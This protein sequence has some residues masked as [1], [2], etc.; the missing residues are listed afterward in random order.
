[1]TAATVPLEHVVLRITRTRIRPV[2]GGV[3]R[4]LS[5]GSAVYRALD[6]QE[7][8]LAEALALG[9]ACV[10][11]SPERLARLTLGEAVQGVT[12]ERWLAEG[13]PEA[14]L[15]V[16]WASGTDSPLARAAA[17]ARLLQTGGRRLLLAGED[18]A[19]CAAPGLSGWAPVETEEVFEAS[20]APLELALAS[21]GWQE[22]DGP[23]AAALAWAGA[24][25]EGAVVLDRA[26]D[27]AHLRGLLARARGAALALALLP[28]AAFLR[29]RTALQ[30]GWLPKTL[31]GEGA[32]AA[33]LAEAAG[34]TLEAPS[35]AAASVGRSGEALAFLLAGQG[36]PAPGL[37]AL[38]LPEAPAARGLAL[39]EAEALRAGRRPLRGADNG[40]GWL[41]PASDEKLRRDYGR[42]A[43]RLREPAKKPRALAEMDE[44]VARVS[45]LEERAALDATLAALGPRALGWEAVAWDG[46]AWRAVDLLDAIAGWQLRLL[47]AAAVAD[48]PAD[49]RLR[50]PGAPRLQLLEPR[51]SRLNPKF[52]WDRPMKDLYRVYAGWVFG[53]TE[54]RLGLGRREALEP[55]LQAGLD[56]LL[57]ERGLAVY[58]PV[59]PGETA[60]RARPWRRA[61]ATLSILDPEG[62]GRDWEVWV[63]SAA[64]WAWDLDHPPRPPRRA[65][66]G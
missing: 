34:E 61:P 2:Q 6:G 63:G 37:R 8:A 49:P 30:R 54:F 32:A 25:P 14:P 62:G 46:E 33:A 17:L 36:D 19:I 23:A 65:A 26:P 50:P 42:L 1:M 22:S 51:K 27:I 12:L 7:Q 18:P 52:T 11:A 48:L 28:H 45:L 38:G 15:L 47:D 31:A 3:E 55:A 20:A 57:A 4:A 44:E 40:Y 60:V 39:R 21:L 64:V 13:A 35:L 5:Q 66:E 29:L 10:V 59:R 43:A 58:L 16:L 56:A 24:Q 9:P 53:T 41:P